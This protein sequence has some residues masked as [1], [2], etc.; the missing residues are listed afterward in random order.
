M[1]LTP[2]KKISM[3]NVRGRIKVGKLRESK[4]LKIEARK[5]TLKTQKKK[6]KKV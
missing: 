2:K 1:S 3:H 5:Q 4:S 6:K